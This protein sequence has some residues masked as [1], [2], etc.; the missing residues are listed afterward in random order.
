MP[1]D[2][3][4]ARYLR[5]WFTD[6]GAPLERYAIPP[7]RRATD[8]ELGRIGAMRADLENARLALVLERNDP[9]TP[10][11]RALAA[12]EM[13]IDTADAYADAVLLLTQP[14]Q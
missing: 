6:D 3:D 2:D 12:A 8:A 9:R 5:W 4:A 7:A 1:Y 13:L 10:A 11:A 14:R